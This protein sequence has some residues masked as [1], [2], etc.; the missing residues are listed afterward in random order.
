M[1]VSTNNTSSKTLKMSTSG[2]FARPATTPRPTSNAGT[3]N[4]FVKTRPN[5]VVRA[6]LIKNKATTKRTESVSSA[7]RAKDDKAGKKP[8][9]TFKTKLVNKHCTFYH[10]YGRCKEGDFCAYKHDPSRVEVCKLW[11]KGTECTLNSKC[12]LQHVESAHLIP[13]CRHFCKG[14]CLK[15]DCHYTHV[16]VSKR[17]PHCKDFMVGRYCPAGTSCRKKHEWGL[18]EETESEADKKRVRD[19]FEEDAEREKIKKLREEMAKGVNPFTAGWT[20]IPI[21]DDD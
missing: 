9:Q 1:A 15:D 17:A 6:D 13:H 2:K 8:N 4:L 5:T 14:M 21:D 12:P 19:S 20:F 10:K 7:G 18:Y 16:K 11:L 3:S